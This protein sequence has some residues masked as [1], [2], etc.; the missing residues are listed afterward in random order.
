MTPACRL[1]PATFE[2]QSAASP[3]SAIGAIVC[4][5]KTFRPCC[6]PVGSLY[7]FATYK[8][9]GKN[10]ISPSFDVKFARL[11]YVSENKFNLSYMRH[12][13]RWFELNAG[14]TGQEYCDAIKNEPY[15]VLLYGL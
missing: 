10:A 11:I 2:A 7:F 1:N 8:S 12:N 4:N 15:F 13:K 5:V 14:L 9:Y 3:C 6:L